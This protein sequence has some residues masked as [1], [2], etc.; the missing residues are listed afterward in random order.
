MDSPLQRISLY[1]LLLGLGSPVQLHISERSRVLPA[2]RLFEQE[3]SS[4]P[5]ELP[6]ASYS[7]RVP[8]E[9]DGEDD[10]EDVFTLPPSSD[11]GDNAESYQDNEHTFY[12]DA[13]ADA[14]SQ[15]DDNHNED[16][17][18]EEEAEDYEEEPPEGSDDEGEGTQS[19]SK[20]AHGAGS[21]RSHFYS[22][23][24]QYLHALACLLGG[25]QLRQSRRYPTSA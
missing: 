4:D 18:R 9:D 16:D 13:D 23:V 3:H 6:V 14:D 5:S 19:R 7:D 8:S 24:S 21:V 10:G 15:N 20:A 12:Q 25:Q 17:D 11:P 2:H 22:T 1:L